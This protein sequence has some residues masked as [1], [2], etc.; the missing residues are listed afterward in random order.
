[1]HRM[2]VGLFAVAI[3]VLPASAV[4][5]RHRVHL[6]PANLPHALTVDEREWAVQPSKTIVGAGAVTFNAYNRGQDD[7]NF[8]IV[9]ATGNVLGQASLKS[10]AS[11]VVTARLHPGRYVLF[12]SLFQG[13]PESH[14]AR[15]MHTT[16][17]VR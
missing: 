10:G 17:F 14:Y 4:A 15:G 16:L 8:V 1:M 6:P 12:C 13:T 5:R 9:D 7:H 3:G 2:A 11:A